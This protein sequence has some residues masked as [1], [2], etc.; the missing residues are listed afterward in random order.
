MGGKVIR[1]YEGV[2]YREN[3]KISTFRKVI[4]K[5]FDL[6]RKYKN[7]NNELMQGLAKLVMNSLYGNQIRKDI[8]ESYYCESEN[9]METEY[10]EN[11]LDYWK[12]SNGKYIVK[13][14]KAMDEMRIVILKILY[15]RICE[16]L[17]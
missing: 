2:I 16:L 14:K 5:L 7:E 15:Q 1:I 17:Y 6:K 8:N 10:D 3:F 9:W 11:V 12:F 4:E 13:I